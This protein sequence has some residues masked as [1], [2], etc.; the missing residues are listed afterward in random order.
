LTGPGTDCAILAALACRTAGVNSIGR[1]IKKPLTTFVLNDG[2]RRKL[3]ER[4][5][6]GESQGMGTVIEFPADAASR[7]LGSTMDGT[8][9]QVRGTVVILPVIRIE[10]QA[11]ETSGDRG[12]EQGAAPGRRRRRR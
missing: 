5:T 7:R 8:N 3:R 4:A 11:E 6:T 2:R 12:P 10:R 1:R 9:P